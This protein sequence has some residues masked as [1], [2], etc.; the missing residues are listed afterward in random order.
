MNPEPNSITDD[1]LSEFQ[2]PL[3]TPD[4]ER[5][6]QE[7]EAAKTQPPVTEEPPTKPKEVEEESSALNNVAEAVAAIPISGIDFGMDVVGMVPGLGGLDDAYDEY[8][9]FKNP[10]IQKFREVSSIILPSLFGTGLVLNGVTKLGK[11]STITK[12]LAS[13]GGVAAVDAGVTYVSDTTEEGDNLLRGLDD[14]TGG[15]L[16]IPDNLMTL[17]SDSTEVRRYKNTVE[18][19]GLSI[20]GDILGY[21]INFGKALK[22]GKVKEFMDWFKPSDDAAKAFKASKQRE[23]PDIRPGEPPLEATL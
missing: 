14:L 20:F 7:Q 18:A 11:I 17:D 6:K 9:K 4:Q 3:L 16:N 15:A 21:G 19:I 5:E 8:T 13:L 2:D 12:A 1:F 23:A 22:S 10:Y